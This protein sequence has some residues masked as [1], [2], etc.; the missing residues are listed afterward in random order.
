MRSD[1][2]LGF[3]PVY[4]YRLQPTF[5]RNMLPPYSTLKMKKSSS[6][7]LLTTYK[8]QWCHNP[9]YY[10]LHCFK[11]QIPYILKQQHIIQHALSPAQAT[12]HIHT[13]VWYNQLITTWIYLYTYHRSGTQCH[14]PLTVMTDGKN[15]VN[16]FIYSCTHPHYFQVTTGRRERDIIQIIFI[17]GSYCYLKKTVTFLENLFLYCMHDCYT[18]YNYWSNHTKHWKS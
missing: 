4:F 18:V 12:I 11:P 14:K 2:G 16:I 5:W 9:Q 6:K 15:C 7:M 3:V 10:N 8:A 17:R 1:Y 13:V